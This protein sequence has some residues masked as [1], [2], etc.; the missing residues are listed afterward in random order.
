MR[1][2]STNTIV[3]IRTTTK[4]TNTISFTV[5]RKLDITRRCSSELSGWRLL[6]CRSLWLDPRSCMSEVDARRVHTG[7]R[8]VFRRIHAHPVGR[9]NAHAGVHT[10]DVRAEREHRAA[11][12]RRDAAAVALRNARLAERR[13]RVLHDRS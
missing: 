6:T 2:I 3:P 9:A 13:V 5:S 7:R 12:Q 4:P 10:I 8:I 1:S 11:A